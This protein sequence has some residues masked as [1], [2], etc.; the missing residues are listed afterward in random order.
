M[1][2]LQ[3]STSM[4]PLTGVDFLLYSLA[5]TPS[6][7]P[8]GMQRRGAISRDSE[9]SSQTSRLTFSTGVGLCLRGA[10][11]ENTY[12]TFC[13]VQQTFHCG[14]DRSQTAFPRHPTTTRVVS[15]RRFPVIVTTRIH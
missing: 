14:S 15:Y 2:D 5:R 10:R 13:L 11:H 12:A 7:N 6:A 4:A 1:A 8:R 3:S 9:I